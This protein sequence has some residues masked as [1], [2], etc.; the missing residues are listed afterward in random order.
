[1]KHL[2]QFAC[3]LPALAVQLHADVPRKPLPSKYRNLWIN[4]PFTVK[5]T[6]ASAPTYNPLQDYVLL[7]VSPI[8]DGY[9]VTILNS[10][11]PQ[12]ERIVI[13]TN[14]PH[15]GIEI[16]E[17]IRSDKERWDGATPKTKVKIS[18]GGSS[19][20]IGYE[21]KFLA[22]KPPPAAATQPARPNIQVQPSANKPQQTGNRVPRRRIV[23]PD[24]SAP[25]TQNTN[26]RD[27]SGSSGRT[28]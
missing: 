13:E 17:V 11:R 26:Q 23:S 14:R 28:R 15:E 1:M 6:M 12:D 18:R 9:R 5:P 16:V 25:N 4:S 22:L 8:K 20:I 3:L 10:K 24:A 27:N 21:E 19:A 7:G 2:L